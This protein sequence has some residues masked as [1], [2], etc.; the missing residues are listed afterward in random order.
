VAYAT[1][2]A[3]IGALM[4]VTVMVIVLIAACARRGMRAWILLSMR[5]MANSCHLHRILVASA[6]SVSDDYRIELRLF[7]MAQKLPS[8]RRLARKA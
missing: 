4:M 7:P 2:V 5:V 8:A 3:R 1:G 6:D